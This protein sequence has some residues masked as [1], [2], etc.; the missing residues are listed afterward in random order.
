MKTLLIVVLSFS[1]LIPIAKSQAQV[2]VYNFE[3][4]KPILNLSNDTTYVINFWATWCVPCIKELPDFEKL[5]AEYKNEKFKMILVSLDFRKS[6]ESRLIPYVEK[7]DLQA[8][9]IMLHEPDANAWIPQVDNSWSGA[10]PATIIYNSKRNFRKF[11]EGSYTYDE[12]NEIVKPLL[13][14]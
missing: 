9:V 1:I 2:K 11:H 6:L 4:F 3:E 8:E 12:L 10:I 7:N 13:I 5:N 14:P